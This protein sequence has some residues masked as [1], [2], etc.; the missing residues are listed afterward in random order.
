[1]LKLK[2][3][4]LLLVGVLMAS[5]NSYRIEIHKTE[6]SEYYV[7]ARK[8]IPQGYP[9]PIWM[10]HYQAFNKQE[11]AIKQINQWKAEENIARENRN[12]KFIYVK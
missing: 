6:T 8:S 7:A 12:R 11:D 2:M 4:L 10:E 1:M 3:L 9:F 5:C